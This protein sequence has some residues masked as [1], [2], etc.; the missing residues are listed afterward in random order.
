[1]HILE[2]VGIGELSD[3]R[4]SFFR[5]IGVDSIHLELRG[6]K[7]QAGAKVRS[8]GAANSTLAQALRAG[9]D[10]TEALEKAREQVESHGL[11]LNNVFMSA[12]QE[13]TLDEEDAD[14]KIGHWCQMLESLG[15]AGIPCLGWNFKPMGNF[16]TTSDVGRSGVQWPLHDG[17]HAALS[18]P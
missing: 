18:P 13:I 14:E 3:E 11:K 10:C 12:W 5:A 1:M 15:R 6:G 7:P 2:Q 9:Q 4:L 8:T 16:R 17:L